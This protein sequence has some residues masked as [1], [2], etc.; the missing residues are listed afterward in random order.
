MNFNLGTGSIISRDA[1]STDTK[2]ASFILDDIGTGYFLAGGY[3]YASSNSFGIYVSH[4]KSDFS[5]SWEILSQENLA[6]NLQDK[7]DFLS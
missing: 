3:K 4:I 5:L 6:S 1:L 7:I 2:M